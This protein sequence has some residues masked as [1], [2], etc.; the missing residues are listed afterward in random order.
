MGD[1]IFSQGLKWKENGTFLVSVKFPTAPLVAWQAAVPKGNM[2]KFCY[3][4]IRGIAVNFFPLYINIPTSWNID[5]QSLTFPI[6][7]RVQHSSKWEIS[8]LNPI[9]WMLDANRPGFWNVNQ[10]LAASFSPWKRDNNMTLN[11]HTLFNC[12]SSYRQMFTTN[13]NA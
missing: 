4:T 10:W 11:R 12:G 5:K 13:L 1:F 3:C 8:F 7:F 2:S 6:T 9:Q